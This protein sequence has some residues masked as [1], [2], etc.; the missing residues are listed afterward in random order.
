MRSLCLRCS[1]WNARRTVILIEDKVSLWIIY[2]AL[3][4]AA[5]GALIVIILGIIGTYLIIV[6]RFMRYSPPVPS[7]GKVKN[8][9]LQDAA[10][11]LSNKS[12]LEIV[13]LGSGWG[14]LLLPLA[15]QFPHHRFVGYEL[16][17]LPYYVS[18]F[19]T[20]HLTNLQIVRQ[21]FYEAN[22]ASADLLFCFLL[23]DEMRKCGDNLLPS[24][25]SEALIY[26]NRFV[27]PNIKPDRTVSFGSEYETFYVYRLDRTG[28]E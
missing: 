23:P 16:S 3:L 15:R 2:I 8:K 1:W 19:R 12:G 22:L 18:K 5:V 27:F 10:E 24:L 20:R 21:D 13:D 26:V 11:Y 4:L 6:G 7:S 28:H 9:M 14:T 17:F 25:K